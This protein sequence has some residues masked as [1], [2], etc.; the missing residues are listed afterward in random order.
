MVVAF[1]STVMINFIHN[2]VD[3][4]N[5]LEAKDV[6]PNII[7]KQTTERAKKCRFL[8]MDLDF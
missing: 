1:S 4:I 2:T 3:R 6:L 8:S 5:K 7:R